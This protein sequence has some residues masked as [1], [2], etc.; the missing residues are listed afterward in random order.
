MFYMISYHSL[1]NSVHFVLILSCI[2]NLNQSI[3]NRIRPIG[4]MNGFIW[5][6]NYY[7]LH[8]QILESVISLSTSTFIFCVIKMKATSQI[9]IS[10][11]FTS[12]W[13]KTE[14]FKSTDFN[15]QSTLKLGHEHHEYQT[16]LA[17]DQSRESKFRLLVYY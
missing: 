13:E 10:I 1:F 2:L 4:S 5:H 8:V 9:L 15:I 11:S 7:N 3:I 17:E 14:N 6:V 12:L 16:G